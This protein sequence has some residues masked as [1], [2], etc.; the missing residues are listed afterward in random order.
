MIPSLSQEII[1]QYASDAQTIQEPQ[2]ADFSQGVKVGKTVPAKWWNWLFSA[3]TKRIIQSRNDAENMLTELK[4]VVTDAGITPSGSDNTQLSAAIENKAD[5]QIDKYVVNKKGFYL[6]WLSSPSPEMPSGHNYNTVLSSGIVA[7]VAHLSYAARSSS[8][9][10]STTAWVIFL[11][12]D[13]VEWHTF[14]P[15]NSIGLFNT[16]YSLRKFKD[17]YYMLIQAIEDPGYQTTLNGRLYKSFDLENWELIDS[18]QA[19]STAGKGDSY[20]FFTQTDTTLG[21]VYNAGQNTISSYYMTTTDGT[22]WSSLT[23]SKHV[24]ADSRYGYISYSKSFST[25]N[26]IILGDTYINTTTGEVTIIIGSAAKGFPLDYDMYVTTSGR[27]VMSANQ[28]TTS[29]YTVEAGATT[30][31]QHTDSAS[32]RLTGK[33]SNGAIVRSITRDK[34]ISYDGLT[35]SSIGAANNYDLFELNGMFYQGS[36]QSTDLVNWE[37]IPTLDAGY[38]ITK[39]IEVHNTLLARRDVYNDYKAS[40][41]GGATWNAMHQ[42][43]PN[44]LLFPVGEKCFTIGTSCYV[45][46]NYVNRVLGHTL[47]IR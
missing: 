28:N 12:A 18:W 31:V 5:V 4:N 36:K 14:M 2:G 47:Y 42:S 3:A 1:A 24:G 25:T 33:L 26:G 45:T 13:G 32:G 21:I 8:S 9:S 43:L 17:V 41:D 39:V 6:D 34:Q 19:Y 37:Q 35:F 30:A 10:S 40:T 7:D 38:H 29:W 16:A 27:L 11:T 22:T 44:G 23:L 46:Q 15:S 20:A